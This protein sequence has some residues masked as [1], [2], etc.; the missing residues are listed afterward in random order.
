MKINI[1]LKKMF[2]TFLV[3]ECLVVPFGLFGQDQGV[4]YE[5]AGDATVNSDFEA[6]LSEIVWTR[7]ALEDE[8]PS[9]VDNSTLP[10]GYMP[11]I[12]NQGELSSC[13]HCAEI[14]YVFTYELNRFLDVVAGSKWKNGTEQ[15]MQNLYHPLFTYNFVNGGNGNTSTYYGSAFN[16]VKEE[17]CPSLVDFYDPILNQSYNLSIPL[18]YRYWMSGVEK[19]INATENVISYESSIHK[20][21]WGNTYSSLDNLKRWIYNGNADGNIGGGLAIISVYMGGSGNERY[22]TGTIP[23]GSSHEGETIM[24]SWST[25]GGHALTIVGYDD[26]IWVSGNHV[27]PN[28]NTPLANC[29]K[30]AFKIAN[31][32]GTTWG[33]S[34]YIWVPYKLFANDQLQVNHRAYIC[35][36]AS[37]QEKQV[38]LS[39]I[40]SHPKRGHM[41][42]RVGKGSNA[43]VEEPEATAPFKYFNFQGGNDIPMNGNEDNPEPIYLS[44]NFGRKFNP[45]SC[46]KYFLQVVDRYTGNYTNGTAYV[47][48]IQ[49]RDYRWGEVFVL[50]APQ[51]YGQI[52]SHGTTTLSIDY[53]LIY[54]FSI[55]QNYTCATNKVARRTVSVEDQYSLTINEGVHLDMYGTEAYNCKLLV[56]AN[57][58]L[59]I[60]DNAI[61]TAKRGDCEIVVN[62]NIQIGQGVTFRAENGATLAITINGQQTVVIDGCTFENTTLLASADMTSTASLSNASSCSVSNCSF[63]ALGTQYAHA[64]RIE[65]YSSIMI[66]DNT[67]NGI[68][69]MSSRHYTDGILIYNC[70]TSGIGSQILRNTIR[71]CV[72]TGLTL[73]GTTADIKGKNEITQC[74]TGVK[75][76]NGSTVNNFMGICGAS[77]ANQTQYIHDNDYCEVSIYRGCMP[78]NFRFNCITSSGNGWFVEYED[79]VE[80][81]KGL[82]TR[83]DLEYNTWGNYTDTQIGSHFNYITNTTNGVV[84]DF[85][86]KW[87]YGECLSSYDEEAQRKSVEADSLWSIG[88]YA[89]AKTSYREIA[90][91]YPN[92]NS[93]LNALKKLLLIEG[94]DG[95][96]YTGLQYYYLNDTT[97]QGNESLFALASS[98]A[99]KCDE[100]LENYA[101]AIAWYET[102]I[103]D[104][105]TPYNDSIF[106]T[107]D[108]GNLYLRM[109]A[110]G[111]K[112]VEGKLNQFVPKSA[113]AFAKQTD[114]A[115][116]KLRHTPRR[117]NPSRELPDQYWTDI[118]TEQPEGYVVD[119]NGDVHL[120]SAEALAWLIS[121]TNGLNGQETDDFDDKTIYLEENIDLS[122]A[123]W[124][125]IAGKNTVIDGFKG[126][127]D[128]K[129]HVIYGLTMT[130]G[131]SNYWAMGLFGKTSEATLSNII[132]KNGYYEAQSQSNSEGG[133]LANQVHKSTIEHCFVECEMHIHEGMSPFV[134]LCDSSTIYNCLVHVPLYR[135]DSWCTAIPGVFAAM[136]YPTSHIY[137][138][139]SII[140]QMDWSEHCGL[141][142]MLNHGIIE[143]CYV[144]IHEILNFPGYG[145]GSGL[146]PRNGITG[147]NMGEVYNCY[148][149]RIR[150]FDPAFSGYYMQLDDSPG[151][152]D[153]FYNTSPFIEEGRGHWKLNE[154][155]SF[156]LENGMVST[157]DLLDA[158]NLKVEELDDE[159]LLNWCDTGMMVETRQL[160]VFCNFDT[161]Q[162]HESKV[163]KDNVILYPNPTNGFV[164]IEGITASEV[165]VY[166]V[167]GQLVKV[168]MWT[169]EL[170]LIGLTDG[171]Y[172][173]RITDDKGTTF[174]KRQYFVK[175]FINN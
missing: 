165:Q 136:S 148:Y 130:N 11:P 54:P 160:P 173:L 141:I 12:F 117:L 94:N 82:C 151:E 168:V 23:V 20:I 100:L 27:E 106:A 109:E 13:V 59:F 47:D 144:Y 68:G 80:N 155:I 37:P 9:A 19:Y 170:N 60:G 164:H 153:N 45:Y 18:P 121:V 174:T 115:L 74:H 76:L 22:T 95:E 86:P 167:Y 156:E 6:S 66:A 77:N 8:L 29:Q 123:L 5:I 138:C 4:C 147:N 103:E 140:E 51:S 16:I 7:E 34:G 31:S 116:R 71:G 172:L 72:E 73:Y 14:A 3:L 124:I 102:I 53:D 120:Y 107:I 118:V 79:N 146:G 84:F 119:G 99:N 57:A 39:A 139:A 131:I 63:S 110:N 26:D 17:G 62:G 32:W 91:L 127:F 42:L 137:N 40:V 128:G 36:V 64:L 104:E 28:A 111:T 1:R 52:Q 88:L 162:I 10:E 169:N 152:G 41:Q 143:N 175:F 114:E 93:A 113:E 159:T 105:A 122:A 44:L 112:G 142:G 24:T 126:R 81:D 134:Y 125:P 50:D 43:S 150:N 65:G 61:I 163:D 101:E 15:E 25:T 46:G 67:V 171:M 83:L 33:N 30:G 157:D 108:L 48:N 135:S 149:N 90:T 89:S 92:T 161:M 35:E 49:L 58:S 75:L 98:L 21:E 97:I 129:E 132:L 55:T 154:F 70:G 166:N 38:F 87:S 158:L 56:N 2:C 145:G 96:D 133:F 69:L 78:Q 85:L